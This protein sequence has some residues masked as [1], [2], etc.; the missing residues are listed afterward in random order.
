MAHGVGETALE[1]PLDQVLTHAATDLV[2]GDL[3]A[4]E[5]AAPLLAMRYQSARLHLAQHRG[6]GGV[7]QVAFGFQFAMDL[8]NRGVGTRP[9]GLQDA[10]LQITKAMGGGFHEQRPR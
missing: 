6:D 8:G 7:G 5:K 1:E 10:Q 4:V 2:G 9:E 3:R